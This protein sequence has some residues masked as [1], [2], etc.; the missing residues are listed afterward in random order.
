MRKYHAGRGGTWSN[1]RRA[2][3]RAV[4]LGTAL[5]AAGALF[6]VICGGVLSLAD[7]LPWSFA[8]AWA[9]R[10]AFAG[11]AAGTIMG[12][13]SAI[14]H[15]EETAPEAAPASS[16]PPAAGRPFLP[17]RAAVALYRSRVHARN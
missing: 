6:G 17:F 12:A 2:V 4:L 7:G 1:L 5:A 9:L 10:G 13:L 15:V 3:I 8:G 11:L 16:R 14:Y